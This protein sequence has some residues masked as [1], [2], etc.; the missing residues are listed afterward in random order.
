MEKAASR[1]KTSGTNNAFAALV[2]DCGDENPFA[3]FLGP[4][5]VGTNHVNGTHVGGGSGGGGGGG[6]NFHVNMQRQSNA[7]HRYERHV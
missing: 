2:K 5:S 4:I 1:A 3:K 7:N 6:G